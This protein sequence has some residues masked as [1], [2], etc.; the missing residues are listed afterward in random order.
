MHLLSGGYAGRAPLPSQLGYT[1]MCARLLCK[2]LMLKRPKSSLGTTINNQQVTDF[3]SLIKN[4]PRGVS[5]S[6]LGL[7]KDQLEMLL[8]LILPTPA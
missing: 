3:C 6:D 7:S 8:P 1:A 5:L 4:L 2:E